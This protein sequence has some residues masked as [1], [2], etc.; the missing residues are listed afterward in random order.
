MLTDISPLAVCFRG[1][2]VRYITTPVVERFPEFI[3]GPHVLLEVVG[4]MVDVAN[5]NEPADW[6][7]E[8]SYGGRRL[9][10]ERGGGVRDLTT[11]R[12]QDGC[13]TLTFPEDR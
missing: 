4:R 3:I 1:Y 12:H 11:G 8:A 13:W 9:W 5:A 7:F 10:L 2:P 6:Y